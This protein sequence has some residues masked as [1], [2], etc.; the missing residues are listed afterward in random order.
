MPEC[1]VAEKAFEHNFWNFQNSCR[2]RVALILLF[3]V[4]SLDDGIV[5]G[6]LAQSDFHTLCLNY[7]RP[8][9]RKIRSCEKS[10]TRDMMQHPYPLPSIGQGE[11]RQTPMTKEE[12][13]EEEEGA[14]S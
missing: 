14:P 7:A 10:A 12:L 5:R 3:V 6:C 13:R 4:R 8:L 1:L 9:R 2:H 11:W